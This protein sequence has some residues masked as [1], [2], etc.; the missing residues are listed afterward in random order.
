[1]K[2]DK[3]KTVLEFLRW[4]KKILRIQ[5]I[6]EVFYLC[7]IISFGDRWSIIRSYHRN[8]SHEVLINLNNVM[9]ISLPSE[10]TIADCKNHMWLNAIKY[11]DINTP[12]LTEEEKEKKRGRVSLFKHTDAAGGLSML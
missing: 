9:S 1:M 8:G 11:I 7:R 4:E 6:N 2:R 10:S 12:K 3:S 5:L